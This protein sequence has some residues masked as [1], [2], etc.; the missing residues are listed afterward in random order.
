MTVTIDWRDVLSTLVAGRTPAQPAGTSRKDMLKLSVTDPYGA[1][2]QLREI[3]GWCE[4]P[5]DMADFTISLG[6]WDRHEHFVKAAHG[7]MGRAEIASCCDCGQP[8]W[9]RGARAEWSPV[10]VED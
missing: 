7:R 10:W 3:A 1:M 8:V 5:H 4:A 9:R 6:Q 2:A